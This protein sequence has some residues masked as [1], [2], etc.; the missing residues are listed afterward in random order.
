MFTNLEEWLQFNPLLWFPYCQENMKSYV[1]GVMDAITGSGLVCP[2]VMR[3]VFCVLK[4]VAV[5]HYPGSYNTKT[6]FFFFLGGRVL[7][8]KLCV[9]T[10]RSGHVDPS[11]AAPPP[12]EKKE[13]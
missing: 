9:C 1:R 12:P 7:E 8:E 6:F 11:A 10:M 5:K 4:E 2:A 13:A 3:D